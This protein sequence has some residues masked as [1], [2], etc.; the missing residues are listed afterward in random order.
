MLV[1]PENFPDF[2][3][4]RIYTVRTMGG[5]VLYYTKVDRLQLFGVRISIVLQLHPSGSCHWLHLL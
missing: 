4:F 2:I 3:Y 5:A 1:G